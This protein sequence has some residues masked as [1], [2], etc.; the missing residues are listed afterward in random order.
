M[1]AL[2]QQAKAVKYIPHIDCLP[3]WDTYQHFDNFAT[4][5]LGDG[6]KVGLGQVTRAHLEKAKARLMRMDVVIILEE[7]RQHLPQFQAFFGWHMSDMSPDKPANAHQ[8]KP[9]LYS[10]TD[11][12]KS[13]L[14]GRNHLDYEL[15][16][17]GRAVAANRTAAALQRIR[18]VDRTTGEMD[19]ITHIFETS[20]TTPSPPLLPTKA[21][22]VAFKGDAQSLWEV[23]PQ[24]RI[25][26]RKPIFW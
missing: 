10:F 5:S 3:P 17:F 9:R 25:Q 16:A 26:I 6:Y 12:E 18:A 22:P 1:Y 19:G 11:S 4:R 2:R 14:R 23:S 7:L 8:T 20:T 15:L 24:R 13:F 21:A